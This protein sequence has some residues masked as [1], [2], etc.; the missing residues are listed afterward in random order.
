MGYPAVDALISMYLIA[1]GDFADREGFMKVPNDANGGKDKVV[2]WIMFMVACF[3]ILII[4][5]NMLIAVMSL[6]FG[7]VQDNKDKHLNKFK[8]MMILDFKDRVDIQKQFLNHK[9]ILVVS[10][11]ESTIED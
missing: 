9:Y 11:E 4:F 8:V 10:P 2:A 7:E 6:P 5:M 1:L 3:L